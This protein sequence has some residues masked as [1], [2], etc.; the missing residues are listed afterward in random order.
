MPA[1]AGRMMVY[2][3]C[4][5]DCW[6]SMLSN[7][8][9]I[10]EVNS[11][12]L[13][14]ALML[15]CGMVVLPRYTSD[16]CRALLCNELC[17]SVYSDIQTST[18]APYICVSTRLWHRTLQGTPLH[19]GCILLMGSVSLFATFAVSKGAATH[20]YESVARYIQYTQAYREILCTVSFRH[21]EIKE[22]HRPEVCNSHH[23][24]ISE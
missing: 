23:S 17:N 16:I 2:R 3:D 11:T 13:L 15:L 8:N 19:Y 4:T 5:E 6:E 1:I 21:L 22:H 18:R 14:L 12:S 24:S 9:C 10:H 7:A 20:S